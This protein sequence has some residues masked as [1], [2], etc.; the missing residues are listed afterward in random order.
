MTYRCQITIQ[1]VNVT[2]AE[3]SYIVIRR[4]CLLSMITD[5][6][7]VFLSAYI[8]F[9]NNYEQNI[10]DHRLSTTYDISKQDLKNTLPVALPY[11][12]VCSY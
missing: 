8:F 3:F 10:I 4:R 2:E 1:S 7:D 11:Y 12:A 9:S 6:K 5:E